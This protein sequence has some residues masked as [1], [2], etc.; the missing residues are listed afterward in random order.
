MN[1]FI[2]LCHIL[3]GKVGME[4][5]IIWGRNSNINFYIELKFPL[6]VVVTAVLS[7][8]GR[9]IAHAQPPPS[10]IPCFPNLPRS[11]SLFHP[12]RNFS[13]TALRESGEL[14]AFSRFEISHRH[15]FTPSRNGVADIQSSDWTPT[16]EFWR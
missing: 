8:T 16:S 2:C 5:L 7:F 3:D 15:R 11:P 14:Q 4:S 13:G 6:W 9:E 10:G 12:R 1:W